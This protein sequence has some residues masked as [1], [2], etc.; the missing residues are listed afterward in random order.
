MYSG[1][2]EDEQTKFIVDKELT[3]K[4]KKQLEKV[5]EMRNIFTGR[6]LNGNIFVLSKEDRDKLV[7]T[8]DEFSCEME[9]AAFAQVSSLSKCAIYR[10]KNN[11]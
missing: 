10:N 7:K 5:G 11:F 4:F 9:R 1:V 8:F 6:I 3:G 2:D